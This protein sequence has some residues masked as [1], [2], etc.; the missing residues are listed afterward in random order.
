MFRRTIRRSLGLGLNPVLSEGAGPDV[1]GQDVV[2]GR[3]GGAPVGGEGV[4]HGVGDVQ[5]GEVAGQE[6][7]HSDFVGGGQDGRVG[8]AAP[9]GLQ[10]KAQA[11]KLFHVWD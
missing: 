7:L 10:G 5:E 8:A 11:G 4:L 6:V 2:Q 3:V 1:G 9:A